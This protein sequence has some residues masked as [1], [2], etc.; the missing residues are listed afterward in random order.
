MLSSQEIATLITALGCGVEQEKDIDEAPLPPHHHHDGRRRR[1][2]PHPHAAADVLLPPVSARCS[3]AA[4]S[5]SRSRRSTRSRRA[6][7]SSTSRT[8]RRSRTTCSTARPRD[9]KLRR[10]DGAATASRATSC[11]G[12]RAR[13]RNATSALLGAARHASATR[14][15]STRSSKSAPRPRTTSRDQASWLEALARACR[16]Y[17]ERARARARPTP[18]SS[19]EPGQR[20]RRLQDRRA[21][22]GRRRARA[23]P[24]IDFELHGLAR[25]RRAAA[26][27]ARAAPRSASAALRRSSDGDE[28][29]RVRRASTSSATRID[30]LGSK[31]LADPALQ[32]PGRDERRAAVGDHD[33]SRRGAR[34]SRSASRTPTR[35][36]SIF[37]TLM[38]DLVEPRREFIEKNALNVR[39]LDV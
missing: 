33:G 13:R 11:A 21:G 19:I 23:R 31:G 26:L 4:T 9:L 1:R 5:T 39:N 24:T 38:G 25:V 37:T 32:G 3:S 2:Q 20:A 28:Q 36:T 17:F 34:C 16:Q 12:A 14:A 30:E 15:S 29:R 22:R 10:G 18:S 7:R 35:P 6:R 27:S 8:S